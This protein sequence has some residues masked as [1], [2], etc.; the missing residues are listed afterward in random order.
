MPPESSDYPG[1][2]RYFNAV[3]STTQ[4]VNGTTGAVYKSTDTLKGMLKQS[5]EQTAQLKALTELMTAL[6]SSLLAAFR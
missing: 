6:S 3:Q 1:G 4:A 2:G 5:E